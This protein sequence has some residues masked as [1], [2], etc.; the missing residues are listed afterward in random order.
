MNIRN[1]LSISEARKKIFDIADEVQQPNT[2]FTLTEKGRPKIVIMS[3][4][5][6]ES[7]ME[8]FEVMRD[9][10]DL[11][12]DI[13]QAEEEYRKGETTTLEDYLAQ[14]G[15]DVSNRTLKKS[16]KRSRKN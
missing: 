4:E 16:K 5:E 11:K 12:E 1:T 2:Y 14:E 13:R 3:A 15:Y 8:T 6:F 10:P 9:F 7:W